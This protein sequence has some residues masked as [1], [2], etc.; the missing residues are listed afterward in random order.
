MQFDGNWKSFEIKIRIKKYSMPG[1]GYSAC[2]CNYRLISVKLCS[3]AY[4]WIC[5]HFIFPSL[6]FLRRIVYDFIK[7][8]TIIAMLTGNKINKFYQELIYWLNLKETR[9]FCQLNAFSF[10][11]KRKTFL[12]LIGRPLPPPHTTNNPHCPSMKR[13][14]FKSR[15]LFDNYIFFSALAF[16]RVIKING[17]QWMTSEKRKFKF[18]EKRER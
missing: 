15:D 12:L 10:N 18:I 8:F 5:D 13:R 1:A 17:V 16:S 2:K 14:A 4:Y 9:C 11:F 7:N 3:S 6:L